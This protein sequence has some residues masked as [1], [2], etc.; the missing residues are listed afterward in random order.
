MSV[1][2]AAPRAWRSD[3]AGEVAVEVGGGS[4]RAVM[5][6]SFG[7]SAERVVQGSEVA[8]GPGVVFDLVE[9]HGVVVGLVRVVDFRVRENLPESVLDGGGLVVAGDVEGE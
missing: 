6:G 8:P 3:S 5:A 9:G 2:S 1:S 4:C 7:C